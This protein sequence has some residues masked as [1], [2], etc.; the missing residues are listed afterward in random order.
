MLREVEGRKRELEKDLE[1]ERCA[2][3]NKDYLYTTKTNSLNCENTLSKMFKVKK[4]IYI[5]VK[6]FV[7]KTVCSVIS[8]LFGTNDQL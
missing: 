8:N 6:T 7:C 1:Q 5:L 2:G 3:Q 4:K